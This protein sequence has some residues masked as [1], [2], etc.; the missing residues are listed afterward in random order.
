MDTFNVPLIIRGRIY[1]DYTE[2][3]GGRKGGIRFL[4]PD[5][6]RHLPDLVACP[7]DSMARYQETPLEEIARFLDE[8]GKVL[9]LDSNR[10]LREAFELSCHTSGISRSIL[11]A[12]Y[13]NVGKKLFARDN[14]LEYAESRIG[15]NYLEGW[16]PRTMRDGTVASVR[17]FGARSVHVIAGNTP[18]VAF[19]TV[20]RSAITRSDCITKTPSNDPLTFTAILRGMIELDPDHPVTRHMSSAYWKGGDET[21]ESKL[22]RPQNIEKIVAW[23]GFD[24][25]KHITR[26][27]QPG[28]DLITLDPK[29]SASI[30]GRDALADDDTMREVARRAACDMGAY[31]QE[32]CANA[33]VIYIE[34]DYDDPAQLEKL[35]RF[36]EYMYAAL[37]AL[38]RY[39]STE[40]KYVDSTLKEEMDGLFM[41]EDWYKVYRDGDISGAVVVSQTDE[42]VSFASSLACRTA[43]LVPLKTLEN[44]VQR[45]NSSTQTVGVW[46][47]A[48]KEAIRDQ[49]A[50][51][52]AQIIISLGYVA[53]INSNGPMDGIEPE[54]RM[55]KWLVDQTQDES[56]PG[57]WVDL[58]G[59][60]ADASAA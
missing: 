29:Q 58:A 56:I 45:I 5:V 38:P 52:G 47:V 18:G 21:F 57:P 12:L 7:P 28:L 30:I 24:S 26:Y 36:G 32:L 4:T 44:I 9:E 31:N 13:R 22:Y 55:L 33:R 60:A 43:N 46:P 1:E 42:P 6:N 41:L 54:R 17:A 48:T 35:N 25:I 10:H 37:Q 49:L 27:L 20:M 50:L 23:G 40:A 2:A 34:C 51:R 3:F 14:I 8:L 15:I 53:R 59:R 39:L 16:V 19:N 11:E